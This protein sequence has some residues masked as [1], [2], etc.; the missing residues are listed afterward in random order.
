[1]RFFSKKEP[2]T[3]QLSI[4]P[5]A[6]S[7]YRRGVAVAAVVK[8]EASYIG[9][10]LHYHRAV[11]INQFIIYDDGSTD[12]TSEVIRQT[13]PPESFQIIPWAGRLIDAPTGNILNSQAIAF[14]HAILNFGSAYRWM[15]FIDVD[16]FLLPK[17]ARTV[18][19]A[20]GAAG[21][22]PVV[23]LPWHMFG[24]GTHVERPSGPVL[25]NYTTR[26]ADPL[27]SKKNVSNFK[28][29]VD[30]CA[31]S[32]VSIHHFEST[33]HGECTAN[34][35]GIKAPTRKARK[36]KSFY[37]SANLQLNHYYT[38]SR[39][40]LE[41]KLARGPASPASRPRYEAR[42]RSAV[43]SIESDLVEDR[44]MIDFL[45]RTGIELEGGGGG[46]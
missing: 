17:S 12:G 21:G 41:A 36:D 46:A 3:K 5:P 38:K 19:D 13:A 28:C 32:K 7:R 8:N 26:A 6:A 9:E 40:E 20:L 39:E 25:R 16:E 14:A 30:P 4:L 11:G 24:P 2:Y 34:D 42:V 27:S 35:A 31:V 29:I 23:S 10:W 1:M 33:Q 45:D 37:S 18:E 22:F 15:A 43:A 44:A